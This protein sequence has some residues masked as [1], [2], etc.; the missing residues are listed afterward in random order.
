MYERLEKLAV[1]TRYVDAPT[2]P[3]FT[4][5]IA[6]C[7]AAIGAY[8]ERNPARNTRAVRRDVLEIYATST[9]KPFPKPDDLGF[10]I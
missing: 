1:P 9:P 3:A 2:R 8:F 10:K 5:E 6:A 7:M 4:P